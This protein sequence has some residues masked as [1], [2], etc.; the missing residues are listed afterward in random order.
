MSLHV[1]LCKYCVVYGLHFQSIFLPV[2]F[3]LSL[4]SAMSG[5]RDQLTLPLCSV[6][7][8]S[9]CWVHSYWVKCQ[10]NQEGGFG[11]WLM[12][13]VFQ[14]PQGLWNVKTSMPSTSFL[15]LFLSLFF[16]PLDFLKYL[17]SFLCHHITQSSWLQWESESGGWG[18]SRA[19]EAPR[20]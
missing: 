15:W 20:T 4:I 11:I 14:A 9:G 19:W 1:L 2:T 7:C 3:I 6:F 8:K 12:T 10:C 5:G 18:S 17:N 13:G 16:F